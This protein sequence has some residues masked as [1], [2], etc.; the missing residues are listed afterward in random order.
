MKV[1][2]Q[3]GTTLGAATPSLDYS[4]GSAT[5]VHPVPVTPGSNAQ[6]K[7]TYLENFPNGTCAKNIYG[8][9]ISVAPPGSAAALTMQVRV[10]LCELSVS[11]VDPGT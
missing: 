10:G 7:V 9:S 3:D 5:G 1:L 8:S 4:V 11:P 6:F 2:S